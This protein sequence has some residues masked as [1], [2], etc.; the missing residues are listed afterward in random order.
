MGVTWKL[1]LNYLK[2]NKKR[3]SIIAICIMISTVLVT[4]VLLL[5][6]SYREYMI[7]GERKDENWEVRF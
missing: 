2:N 4:T 7:A 3:S 6:N 1:A 5:I